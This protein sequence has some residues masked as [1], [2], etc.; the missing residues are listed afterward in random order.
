MQKTTLES[1]KCVVVVIT[2]P[3]SGKNRKHWGQK[4]LVY[5]EKGSKEDKEEDKE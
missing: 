1:G 4:S 5:V 3:W 2:S